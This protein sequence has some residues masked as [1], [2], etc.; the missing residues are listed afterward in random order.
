MRVLAA[1]FLA[2]LVA[3]PTASAALLGIEN[4]TDG[5]VIVA[6]R[7]GTLA[8]TIKLVQDLGGEVIGKN[9]ELRHI[10]VATRDVTGLMASVV[11][12]TT[13]EYAEKND[14]TALHGAQWNGAQWNS[15]TVNG[16]Q[17]NG[18]EWNGAQ[19]NGAQWNGAQWNGAQWNSGPAF[20]SPDPGRSW[21][22]GLEAIAAPDAWNTTT[23][24]NR[25]SLCVLDSGVDLDHPDLVDNLQWGA[26]G[27]RGF[28]AISPDTLPEDDAGHGTHVAGIA[29]ASIGNGFGVA[30][31]G[32]VTILPVK[33]LDSTGYGK[34]DDLAAGLVWCANHGAD[35]ALMALGIDQED[36]P[37]VKRAIEYAAA[38]DVLLV[39]SAGNAGCDCIGLPAKHKDVLAVGAYDPND[40]RASFSNVGPQLDIMAPGVDI[41]STFANGEFRFGSGTSQAAA[42]AAGA[43]ALLRDHDGSLSAA[44]TRDLMIDSARDMGAAGADAS[45]GAGSIDVAAAL[46]S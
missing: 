28:N 11:L 5:E 34:E 38:R 18:A 16:A 21:Q 27:L 29:A 36:A 23:G 6:Y 45:T 2:A 39:A 1:I 4:P 26:N 33:V 20:D 3:A 41:I 17:W 19:W 35:V 10:V 24:T 46:R 31:V 13:V 9:D 14:D 42:Y 8:Q 22:W 32:N 12:A 37:T 44:Q 15:V 25:A 40:T 30:G 7:E 43:A